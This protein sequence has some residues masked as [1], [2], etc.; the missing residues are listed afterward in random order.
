MTDEILLLRLLESKENLEKMINEI[1]HKL[2]YLL[3]RIREEDPR[4]G[5]GVRR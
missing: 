2:D 3:E 1:T 5:P 4:I